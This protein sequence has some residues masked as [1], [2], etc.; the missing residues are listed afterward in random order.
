MSVDANQ[1]YAQYG[2]QPAPAPQQYQA[3]A[4]PQYAPQPQYAPAPQAPYAPNPYAQYQQAAPV[5]PQYAPQSGYPQYANQPVGAPQAAP[6]PPVATGSLSDFYGQT[7]GVAGEAWSFKTPGDTQ[8]GLVTAE[9]TVEQDRDFDTKQ[10]LT[11]RDGSP[12]W[13]MVIPLKNADQTDAKLYVRGSKPGSLRVELAEAMKKAGL[14][15]GTAP[16]VNSVIT[17]QFLGKEARQGKKTSFMQ[18]IFA[19]DYDRQFVQ[20]APAAPVAAPA[21]APAAPVVAPAPIQFPQAPPAPVAPVAPA[22]PVD[23]SQ[24]AAAQAP[25]A[26]A[27]VAPMAPAVAPAPAPA[28]PAGVP[29]DQAAVFAQLLGGGQ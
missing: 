12:V 20:G 21:P 26:P 29:A 25:V 23:F 10:P 18:N 16:E 5:P 1:F 22:A 8:R 2:Q 4:A 19:V 11:Y 24:L 17:V 3:P 9:A 13:I 28:A 27:P 6:L 7:S 14:A 15:E